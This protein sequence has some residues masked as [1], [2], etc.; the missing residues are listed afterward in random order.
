MEIDI[1]DPMLEIDEPIYHNDDITSLI[2]KK[3]NLQSKANINDDNAELSFSV[4]ATDTYYVPHKSHILI[5]GRVLHN[6]NPFDAADE[7]ALINNAMMYIFKSVEYFVAD[8]SME[9]LNNPGQTT[10][11][12]GYLSY[13]DDF[14]S[15]AG[16]GLCW[17]KDTTNNA[18]SLKYTASAA[19]A[20]GAAID[21]GHF[22]P[23]EN[24]NY[25]QGFAARKAFVNSSDPRG[26]FS[27]VI[28][29]SHIFGFAEYNKCL[30]NVRHQLVLQRTNDHL[31]L[32]K[33][34]GVAQG[35][36]VLEDVVWNLPEIKL[37]T[38][39][40]SHAIKLINDKKET[41][42]SYTRRTDN[43]IQLTRGNTNF[44]WLQKTP[45]GIEK[46]RWLIVG[47]QTD[48]RKTQNQNPAVFDHINLQ[49]AVATIGTTRYP[50]TSIVSNFN[51]N[52]YSE[53]YH[54][55][56]SFKKE[57]Y[58][59]NSLIGGS[60]INYAAFKSLYPLIVFDLRHQSDELKS[61]IT[62]IQ[63]EFIFREAIPEHTHAYT[64]ILS[65]SLYKLKSDG[66]SMRMIRK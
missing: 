55:M 7:I 51:R 62:D 15:S 2:Y 33:V 25:N 4:E 66:S 11:M 53:L 60:Q 5:T 36:I 28:P 27:F 26:T 29:F 43:T 17:S 12:L 20:A 47:F 57:Y 46:P 31:A 8:T 54:A 18:S 42:V 6:D 44:N 24:P 38:K 21:A 41:L 45:G 61:G 58:G 49:E 65:D 56:D 22:T 34:N 37:S 50:G 13:P 9:R 63:I 64:V 19:V 1:R 23:A 40:L 52:K 30:Y 10:S 32:F 39:A 48:K 3:V 35:R 59:Y 14:N 16:L